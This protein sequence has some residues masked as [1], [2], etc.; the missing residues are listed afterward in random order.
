MLGPTGVGKNELSKKL[1]SSLFSTESAMIRFDMSEFQE[2]HMVSRSLGSPAGRV[3]YEDA[4]QL[5]DAVRRK[6]DAVLLFD[7]F[8]NAHRDIASLLLQVL[9]RSYSLRCTRTQSR[10]SQHHI[11]LTS[12]LGADILVIADPIHQ[13]SSEL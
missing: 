1:A 2:K 5:N 3:S 12:N 8:K 11:V 9:D 4:G 7:G 10:H 13:D 6:P